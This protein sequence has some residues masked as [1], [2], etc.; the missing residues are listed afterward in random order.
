MWL[1]LLTIYRFCVFE[2][3]KLQAISPKQILIFFI[4]IFLIERNL[5][6]TQNGVHQNSQKVV[7]LLRDLTLYF[8]RRFACRGQWWYDGWYLS[9]E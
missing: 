4:I 7:K 1:Y 3:V 8:W 5:W 6:K 2:H 9:M